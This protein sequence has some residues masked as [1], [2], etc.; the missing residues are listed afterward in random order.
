MRFDVLTTVIRKYV[1]FVIHVPIEQDIL[2]VRPWKL[3][4][5]VFGPFLHKVTTAS[6]S[7]L[8]IASFCNNAA[9]DIV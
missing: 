4:R 1:M 2:P 9:A 8:S 3:I 6:L 5:Q 7:L